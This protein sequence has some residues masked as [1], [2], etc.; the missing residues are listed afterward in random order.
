MVMI[1]RKRPARA[2]LVGW[3]GHAVC[4]NELGG[5][6]AH[7]QGPLTRESAELLDSAPSLDFIMGRAG[8][9]EVVMIDL[10]S[11]DASTAE[12]YAR[13]S[14]KTSGLILRAH[15]FLP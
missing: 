15:G 5:I 7:W 10:G 3:Q 11:S 13:A 8:A 1:Q 6:S 9:K 2:T 14:F 4:G 12:A